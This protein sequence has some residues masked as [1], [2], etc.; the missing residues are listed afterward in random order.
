MIYTFAA[1]F[2]ICV[3]SLFMTYLAFNKV[4]YNPE[5]IVSEGEVNLNDIQVQQAEKGQA[6][7]NQEAVTA[8]E[9]NTE[10]LTTATIQPDSQG[11][12]SPEQMQ[13][14]FNNLSSEAQKKLEGQLQQVNEFIKKRD[15]AGAETIFNQIAEENRG[16]IW[17]QQAK[18]TI[19]RLKNPELALADSQNNVNLANLKQIQVCVF[20]SVDSTDHLPDISSF[21]KAKDYLQNTCGV[22]DK[23]FLDN[24]LQ[25]IT[26][27]DNS[28]NFN[29]LVELKSGK[30]F[31]L[32]PQGIH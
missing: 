22:S 11:T 13:Q 8:V 28:A 21:E 24:E 32:T 25:D 2:F 1:I 6:Q 10:Q 15:L 17:E 30:K 12:A 7:V 4:S 31:S 27:V 14:Q 26:V 23:N 20:S 3:I 16:T 9:N 29:V 5:K 19:R 18:E